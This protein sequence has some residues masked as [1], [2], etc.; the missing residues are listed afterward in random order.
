M[1]SAHDNTGR[2]RAPSPSVDARGGCAAGLRKRR[3]PRV[4]AEL[5]VS[6][7]K[8]DDR[9]LLEATITDISPGGCKL[10][11]DHQT[12][13]R[14]RSSAVPWYAELRVPVGGELEEVAVACVV[15]YVRADSECP[16]VMTVGMRFIYYRGRSYAH[17]YR[18]LEEALIPA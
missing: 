10:R 16:G 7:V 17:L 11:C 4:Q 15:A 2:W 8:T 6:L 9:T 3:Y 12:G 14:L 13:H 18:F 5:A 1:V